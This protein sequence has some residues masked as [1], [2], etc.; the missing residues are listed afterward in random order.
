MK[1]GENPIDMLIEFF[2]VTGL[3]WLAA[4][5]LNTVSFKLGEKR[6]GLCEFLYVLEGVRVGAL[7]TQFA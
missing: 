4:P 1:R 5:N 6:A 7:A 2:L 3:A